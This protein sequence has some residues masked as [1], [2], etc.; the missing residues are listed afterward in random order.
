MIVASVWY[1]GGQLLDPASDACRIPVPG[2]LT[3]HLPGGCAANPR[4]HNPKGSILPSA[5]LSE[6]PFS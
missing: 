2:A 6:S 1:I 4:C 3:L 5:P